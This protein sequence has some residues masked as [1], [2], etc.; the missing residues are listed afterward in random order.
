MCFGVPDAGLA[1]EVRCAAHELVASALALALA[2]ADMPLA[3]AEAAVAEALRA[4]EA[5]WVQAAA[6]H[7]A[8]EVWVERREEDWLDRSVCMAAVDH[9][10]GAGSEGV[11][12]W[13][14]GE[15]EEGVGWLGM[16]RAGEDGE[17][18]LRDEREVL[19]EVEP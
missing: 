5:A 7:A 8:V 16:G 14:E 1:R 19:G 2:A 9:L 18:A 3:S 13:L 12:R 4:R 15:E 10:R 6:E 17:V 11:L